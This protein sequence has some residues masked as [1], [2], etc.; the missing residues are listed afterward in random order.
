VPVASGLYPEPP[1]R[2]SDDEH[3]DEREPEEA[4]AGRKVVALPSAH[5]PPSD[6]PDTLRDKRTEISVIC[7]VADVR[8][9]D[10]VEG[11]AL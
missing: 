1:A 11:A 3:A 5:L 10:P 8:A 4:P 6:D 7:A 2:G 9:R